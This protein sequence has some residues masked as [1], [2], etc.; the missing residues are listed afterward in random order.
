MAAFFEL[1]RRLRDARKEMGVPER[2][3]IAATR[4]ATGVVQGFVFTTAAVD[5][6]RLLARVEIVDNL[7][8][9]TGRVVVAEGVEIALGAAAAGAGHDKA[10]LE[11]DLAAAK[12]NIDRLEQR[13]GNADFVDRANPEVVQRTRE[14]LEA[15]LEKRAALEEAFSRA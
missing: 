6:L 12:A 3:T 5:A 13:L 15:A 1:V 4:R 2:E 7:P 8:A 11:R 10:S 14:Q 9:A